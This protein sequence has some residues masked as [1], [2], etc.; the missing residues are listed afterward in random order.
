MLAEMCALKSTVPYLSRTKDVIMVF[1]E[2]T[3]DDCFT[4]LY[5]VKNEKDENKLQ[6]AVSVDG[7]GLPLI[8]KQTPPGEGP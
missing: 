1:G 6:A 8:S 2:T 7:L 4:R 3:N 5:I